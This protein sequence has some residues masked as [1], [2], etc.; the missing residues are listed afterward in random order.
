MLVFLCSTEE[1]ETIE[2]LNWKVD[3]KQRLKP[4]QN[5]QIIE[6]KEKT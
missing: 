6:F 3:A 4:S 1:E 2:L 5:Y